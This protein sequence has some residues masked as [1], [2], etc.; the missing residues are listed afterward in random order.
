[1]GT[2][3]WYLYLSNRTGWY[4]SLTAALAWFAGLIAMS[5]NFFTI[6]LT[7]GMV[8]VLIWLFLPGVSAHF[9]VKI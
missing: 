9:G 2:A 7:V 5:W 8:A 6:I 4:L 3:A 1:M